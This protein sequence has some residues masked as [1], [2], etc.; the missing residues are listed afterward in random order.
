MDFFDIIKIPI[1]YLL[2]W[3]YDLIPNYGWALIIFT[4]VV[5]L[6]LLPLGLKQQKSMTKMQA[7]QPKLV[8]IQDKYKNDLQ[9]VWHK[10]HG[11]LLAD[12]YSAPDSFCTLQSSLQTSYLYA[13]YGGFSNRNAR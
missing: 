12:A 8:A 2:G 3:I 1:G 6:L 10:S 7:I 11:W 5:K 13:S 4:L 9:R